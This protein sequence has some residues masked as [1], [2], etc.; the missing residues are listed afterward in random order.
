MF[1][2]FYVIDILA[3][4]EH[5]SMMVICTINGLVWSFPALYLWKLYYVTLY[6]INILNLEV[7]SDNSVV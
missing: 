4:F 3:R 2:L 1:K 7:M 5:V 6:Y